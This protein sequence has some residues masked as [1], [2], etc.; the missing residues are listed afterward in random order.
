M[1]YVPTATH[2]NADDLSKAPTSQTETPTE[3]S[4]FNIGQIHKLPVLAS[5]MPLAT[6]GDLRG[7]IHVVVPLKP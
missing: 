6:K 3:V 5:Q 7:G 4:L 1:I 2:C